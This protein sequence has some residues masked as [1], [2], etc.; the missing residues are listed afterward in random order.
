MKEARYSHVTHAR[1]IDEPLPSSYV[2]V[3]VAI[4]PLD[5][6]DAAGTLAFCDKQGKAISLDPTGV[7]D[8]PPAAVDPL[9]R[10]VLLTHS[11][12]WCRTPHTRFVAAGNKKNKVVYER[13][14]NADTLGNITIAFTAV[15]RHW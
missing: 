7:S 4:P 15:A 2:G 13:T 8:P 5:K 10:G 6:L 3:R 1:Y 11:R 12:V 9:V 14:V